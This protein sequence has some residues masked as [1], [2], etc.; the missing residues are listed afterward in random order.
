MQGLENRARGNEGGPFFSSAT[1]HYAVG[2]GE[3]LQTIK[4]FLNTIPFTPLYLAREWAPR[5]RRWGF[6]PFSTS[7]A[8]GL[9]GRR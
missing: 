3:N 8:M 1:R 9:C 5:G 2:K 6:S 7:P 4:F